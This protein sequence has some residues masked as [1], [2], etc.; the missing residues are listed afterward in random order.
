MQVQ[1]LMTEEVIA[2]R[3]DATLKQAASRMLDYGVG[4]IVVVQEGSPVGL[5]TQ[6]DVLEAG[7]VTDK[8]FSQVPVKNVMSHPVV[9]IDP[10][11]TVREAVELMDEHRVKH[12]P[13]DTEADLHGIV[14]SSD[15]VRNHD[16]LVG[17]VEAIER[18]AD[19]HRGT[20]AHEQLGDETNKIQ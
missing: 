16:E 1:Q 5:V 3:Y 12:L 14:T 2:I 7:V 10:T 18:Q 15:I 20:E 8:S 17:E 19:E 6:S 9:T 13:V 4:S 11:A